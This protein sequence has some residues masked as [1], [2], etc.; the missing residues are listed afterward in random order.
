MPLNRLI[1]IVVSV[2]KV[3]CLWL[4]TC[5]A[6]IVIIKKVLGAQGLDRMGLHRH[7]NTPRT[8]LRTVINVMVY[9]PQ[10][11]GSAIVQTPKHRRDPNC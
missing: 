11:C 3:Q 7:Y 10:S 5:I 4:Y 6:I 2:D 9:V 1:G 8:L